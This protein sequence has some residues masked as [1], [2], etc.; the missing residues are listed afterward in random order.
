MLCRFRLGSVIPAC[1][2]PFFGL[3]PGQHLASAGS[4]GEPGR[5]GAPV[6]ARRWMDV[7]LSC[8]ACQTALR[9]ALCRQVAA[10]DAGRVSPVTQRG[11]RGLAEADDH[12]VGRLDRD[13][14]ARS[15]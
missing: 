1:G 12:R 11:E 6:V 10:D 7:R 3:R 14:L 4:S 15:P 8:S 13:L 2:A 5:A 9:L